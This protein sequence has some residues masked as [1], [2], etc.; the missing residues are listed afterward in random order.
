MDFTDLVVP[1]VV[2]LLTIVVVIRT[3]RYVKSLYVAGQANEWVLIINNGEMKRAG[4]GLSCFKGP[5]D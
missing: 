4:I 1:G 3:M 5:F 2:L